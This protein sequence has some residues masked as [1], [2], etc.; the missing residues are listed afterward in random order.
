MSLFN[1]K[2]ER[3]PVIELLILFIILFLAIFGLKFFNM[4]INS[5]WCYLIIILYFILRFRDSFDELK[6]DFFNIFSKVSFGDILIIV[7]LNIFFSYGMLYFSNY[8]LHW[9]DLKNIFF[10]P[11]ICFN[12]ELFGLTSFFSI[13]FISPIVEEFIFR[14]IF[15]NKL[16]FIVPTVFA[17][18]ISSLLFASLHTFGSIFSAFI[19]GICMAILYL[20]SENI[21]VPAFAHFL[22]NF[23][24]ES[25]YHLDSSK[26]LF[27]NDLV[28]GAMS[29]FAI[30]SFILI[31]KFIYSNWKNI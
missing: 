26:M 18:L 11:L 8:V 2:L 22:N 5:T 16:K 15:L 6:I 31:L 10:S 13:V 1:E 30:V 3:I 19:F 25:V 24:G 14:G 12:I 17:V 4:E 7:L 23:I 28:I 21:L 27:N 9:F 20:E 29:I